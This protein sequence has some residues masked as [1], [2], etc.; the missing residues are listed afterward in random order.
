MNHVDLLLAPVR[1][2]ASKRTEKEID[3]HSDAAAEERVL[4]WRT[5]LASPINPTE[6]PTVCASE[7]KDV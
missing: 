5:V 7:L 1:K 3:M 6:Q 4:N 2:E